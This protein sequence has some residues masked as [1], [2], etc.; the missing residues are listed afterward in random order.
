MFVLKE[1]SAQTLV[2]CRH[3][4]LQ[5][6]PTS[7]PTIVVGLNLWQCAVDCAADQFLQR[8]KHHRIFAKYMAASVFAHITLMTPL[9]S[10][11]GVC[12]CFYGLRCSHSFLCGRRWDTCVSE[13]LFR[14]VQSSVGSM[15]WNCAHCRSERGGGIELSFRMYLYFR[16]I[17]AGQ[18]TLSSSLAVASTRTV[19]QIK[20]R[21]PCINNT[22]ADLCC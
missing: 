19:T 16:F 6:W 12:I 20:S 8:K 15:T 22:F 3:V 9:R 11:A 10:C 14:F 7:S 5:F 17:T 21:K 2:P 4:N 18:N 1:Y 13:R